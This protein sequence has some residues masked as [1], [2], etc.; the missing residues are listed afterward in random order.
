M[1]EGVET[2]AN[3]IRLGEVGRIE[4]M[5]GVIRGSLNLCRILLV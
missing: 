3:H 1:G 4:G 2:A 5:Q